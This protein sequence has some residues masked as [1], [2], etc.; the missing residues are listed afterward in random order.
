MA[1][2]TLQRRQGDSFLDCRNGKG[3][4]QHVRRDGA[5]AVNSQGSRQTAA[6]L[7]G[8]RI[9]NKELMEESAVEAS[10]LRGEGDT[11]KGQRGNFPGFPGYQGVPGFSLGSERDQ[12]RVG[13][14][15]LPQSLLLI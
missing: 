11:L 12:K 6:V 7:H 14:T 13:G 9:G 8:H 10:R 1:L 3:V 2:P 4:P 15:R 5:A